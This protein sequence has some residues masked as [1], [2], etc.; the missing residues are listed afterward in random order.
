MQRFEER[1]VT[2]TRRV[3][4]EHTCDLCGRHADLNREWVRGIW[5]VDETDVSV[6]VCHRDGVSYPEGGGGTRRSVDMCPECFTTRLI[7]WLRSQG[8]T[9]REAEWE[10]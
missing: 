5:D 8:A 1:T 9:I 4:V 2:E 3:L 10:S 6:I 7:P